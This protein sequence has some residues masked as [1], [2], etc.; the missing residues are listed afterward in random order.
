MSLSLA[1]LDE[2]AR[3]EEVVFAAGESTSDAA[4]TELA[5]DAREVQEAVNEADQA[6]AAIEEG[7]EVVEAAESLITF[8]QMTAAGEAVTRSGLY[9]AESRF[10]AIAAK[11]GHAFKSV[12]PIKDAPN[13]ESAASSESSIRARAAVYAQEGF[14][15][16]ATAFV[17]R[18]VA[19]IA[20][21]FEKLVVVI[22]ALFTSAAKV[23]KQLE[24]LKSSLGKSEDYLESNYDKDVSVAAK[25]LND[26]TKIAPSKAVASAKSAYTSAASRVLNITGKLKGM[27]AEIAANTADYEGALKYVE[28]ERSASYTKFS[29][30]IAGRPVGQSNGSIV[31]GN[32]PSISKSSMQAMDRKALVSFIDEAIGLA[33][34]LEK[35]K[36]HTKDAEKAKSEEVKL[37][38]EAAAKIEKAS[39]EESESAKTAE[40]RRRLITLTKV[41]VSKDLSS[42][43]RVCNVSFGV[44]LAAKSLAQA[45]AKILAKKKSS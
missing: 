45:N 16:D 12:D 38:N 19:M 4:D 13:F 2:A 10:E 1:F 29:G 41:S 17:K 32:A 18:I 20:G 44:L 14:I 33:E 43:N 25:W 40:L 36:D 31:I 11:A 28:R 5:N 15:Q 39:T 42:L 23:K 3:E 30:P 9:M 26:G 22:K 8:G 35:H 34:V 37:I 24:D 21:W 27:F 6:G 7:V